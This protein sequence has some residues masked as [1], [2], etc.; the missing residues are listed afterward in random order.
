VWGFQ[1]AE[2]L[3]ALLAMKGLGLRDCPLGIWGLFLGNKKEHSQV[4]VDKLCAGWLKGLHSSR[5]GVNF[6]FLLIPG[7]ASCCGSRQGG[8]VEPPGDKKHLK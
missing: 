7:E 1:R 6:S 2:H 5:T 4:D 3:K 8:R